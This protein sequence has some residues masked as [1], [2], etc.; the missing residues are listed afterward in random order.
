MLFIVHLLH[1]MKLVNQRGTLS[2][3]YGYYIIIIIISMS[4]IRMSVLSKVGGSW[5][6]RVHVDLGVSLP[7]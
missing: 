2:V 4:N 6:G 3:C 5:R 7:C 1:P